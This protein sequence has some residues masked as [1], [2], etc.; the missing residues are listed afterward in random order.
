MRGRRRRRRPAVLLSFAGIALAA[1]GTRRAL[2]GRVNWAEL[3]TRYKGHGHSEESR[4]AK[5]EKAAA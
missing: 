1:L 3:R 5:R 4:P 2:K